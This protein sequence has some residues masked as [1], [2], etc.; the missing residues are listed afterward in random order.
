[1]QFKVVIRKNSI[2]KCYLFI[3]VAISYSMKPEPK[4]KCAETGKITLLDTHTADTL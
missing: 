2:T 4:T 1:M 3:V